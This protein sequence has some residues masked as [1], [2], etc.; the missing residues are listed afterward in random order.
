MSAGAL[1][2]GRPQP[3]QR[4]Y[5]KGGR[6]GSSENGF[7][8]SQQK[9]VFGLAAILIGPALL[10]RWYDTPKSEVDLSAWRIVTGSPM[11]PALSSL[12]CHNFCCDVLQL[13]RRSTRARPVAL[14]VRDT[15]YRQA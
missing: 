4:A 3:G 15:G 10:K 12:S 11:V 5:I 7:L 1:P 6:V 2:W 13:Q 14:R 8:T 9:R